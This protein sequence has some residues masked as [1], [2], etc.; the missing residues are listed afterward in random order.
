MSALKSY[1]MPIAMLLG[2]LFY[3]VFDAL[4][5][6]TPYLI[7][8]MLFLTYNT[9]SFRHLSISRAHILLIIIQ[10]SGGLL[11]YFLLRPLNIIVAQ[12]ALICIMAPTATA[13][14]VIA[15]MLGGNIASLATYSLLSNI[16][17]AIVAPIVFSYV[18]IHQDIPFMQS[19]SLISSQVFPL[20][21][22][23]LITTLILRKLLPSV[24]EKLLSFTHVSFYLWVVSLCIVT[25]KTVVFILEQDNSSYYVEIITAI[26]AFFLCLMQFFIGRR[27]GRRYGDTIAGGQG[28]G[29]KNTILAIWMS[30]VYLNPVSSL[31]PGS[32][33][34]W[35]N[36]VNSYQLWRKRKKSG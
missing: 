4:A 20:L 3:K 22:A 17:V 34:L 31:G 15:A 27:I 25:G 18:G 12:A 5:F 8:L 32:Y 24:R 21:I 26:C 6:L 1:M 35:Q 14:P 16:S 11:A 19:F 23:P 13:A 2:I 29:Q 7:F 33:V 30:Q 36:M 9:I 28:L 10:L